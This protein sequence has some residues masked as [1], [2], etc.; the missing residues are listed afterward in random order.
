M[1]SQMSLNAPGLVF[2]IILVSLDPDY[3]MALRQI[4]SRQGCHQHWDALS[5]SS[6][7]ELRLNAGDTMACTPSPHQDT[8]ESMVTNSQDGTIHAMEHRC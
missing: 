5:R 3:A 1:I 4:M 7:L 2:A 6:C 8:D